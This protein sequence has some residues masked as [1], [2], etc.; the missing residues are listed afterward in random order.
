MATYTIK[1]KKIG[2]FSDIHIGLGQDSS[3]WHETVIEFGKWAS[4]KFETLGITEIVIPGDI[5]HNRSEISVKT[6]DL[7][8]DFFDLF[9][10][11]NL[12]ISVGNHD[13]YKKNASDIHSLKLLSE[14]KN[15]TIVD[16]E[17]KVFKTSV[18]KTVSFV[19]WA[20]DIDKIPLADICFGHF[21]IQ[22]FY[23]NGYKLCEHGFE[24]KNLF[25]KSKYIISGHFHKKD[26]REYTDG[27][28]LYVGSPYQQNF[29]DTGDERGIY[30]FDL[31]TEKFNFIENTVSP[32]HKKIKISDIKEKKID[33]EFLKNE[34]PNNLICLIIDQ[35]IT[36]DLHSILVSKIQNLNPKNLKIEYAEPQLGVT[37]NGTPEFEISDISKT[38]EE[39]VD[40]MDV[41]N[42]SEIKTYLS[43][44]YKK[45]KTD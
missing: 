43:D 18:G 9:K 1:S 27:N 33:V 11:F 40:A 12:I 22:S 31:E 25:S 4:K 30:V 6:L 34:I 26:F 19:P 45:L 13:V 17:P 16:V 36:P 44:I 28:I 42:K 23:M 5:F 3:I 7:A 41:Q 37:I 29:G 15:I 2:I 38:I 10:E 35:T 14:W 24:S 8:K 32:L 20:T 21:D 39:Y